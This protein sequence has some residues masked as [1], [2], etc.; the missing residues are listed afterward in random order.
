[1]CYNENKQA[2]IRR[3][4]LLSCSAMGKATGRPPLSLST[5]ATTVTP[6]RIPVY[7]H[8]KKKLCANLKG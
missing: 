7:F 4:I 2:G 3:K 8:V 6:H 5:L 1:M